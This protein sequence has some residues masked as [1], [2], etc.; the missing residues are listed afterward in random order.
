MFSACERN[1][2]DLKDQTTWLA[3]KKEGITGMKIE[4]PIFVIIQLVSPE[5][6]SP[7]GALLSMC[8]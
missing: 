4:N 5:K 3:K 1:S 2:F 6:Q 8:L 7:A